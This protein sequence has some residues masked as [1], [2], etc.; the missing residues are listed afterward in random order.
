M[1][2]G[3]D[4]GQSC[5]QVNRQINDTFIKSKFNTADIFTKSIPCGTFA[6]YTTSMGLIQ[7]Q[8]DYIASTD[9][10]EEREVDAIL[11]P[12]SEDGFQDWNKREY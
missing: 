5:E 2:P 12:P 10:E 8:E 9:E 7:K 6:V 1:R 11:T 4:R 3:L